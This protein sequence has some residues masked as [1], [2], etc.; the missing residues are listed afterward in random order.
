MCIAI[1]HIKYNGA[2]PLKIAFLSLLSN[3]LQINF[4]TTKHRAI[5]EKQLLS[6]KPMVHEAPTYLSTWALL[7]SLGNM[8]QLLILSGTSG[9][10]TSQ[11]P[12][13]YFLY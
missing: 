12:N 8:V 1:V 9:E 3:T 5:D 4:K 11:G 6:H 7:L 10:F 2:F 13:L